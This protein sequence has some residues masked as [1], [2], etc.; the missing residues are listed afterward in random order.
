MKSYRI[1]TTDGEYLEVVKVANV[2]A[3]LEVLEV[4]AGVNI[5]QIKKFE[6]N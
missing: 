4:V 3:M 5:N 6:E 1:W 2:E